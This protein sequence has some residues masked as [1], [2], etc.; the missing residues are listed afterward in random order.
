MINPSFL[1]RGK[2]KDLRD[3]AQRILEIFVRNKEKSER[4][5][6]AIRHEIEFFFF[7][8]RAKRHSVRLLWSKKRHGG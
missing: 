1:N 4:K 5:A 7:A 3:V 6:P 2:P 8:F